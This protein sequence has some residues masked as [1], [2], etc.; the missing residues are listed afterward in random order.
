V[1]LLFLS[2]SHRDATELAVRL[3]SDLE[4]A[5]YSV[6]QDDKRI[7][8]GR[9]WTDEIRQG[10]RESQLVIAVLSPQAV[11]RKGWDRNPDDQDSVCLD[12]IEYA[13][14]ACRVPVLPIM[15]MSCEAPFRIF[16]LQYLD[17]RAWQES[18][19]H[20]ED[21]RRA[22]HAAVAECLQTGRVPLRKWE[23]LPEPC[24]FTAFIAERRRWFTGR[25]WLLYALRDRVAHGKSSTILLTGS[26]GIGK[27]A[28]VANL[29]HNNPAGQILAYHCCQATIPATLDPAV[30]VRSLASMLAARDAA[31]AAMI[32]CQNSL[33][34]LDEARVAADPASAFENVILNQLHKLPAPEAGPRILLIDALDEAVEWHRSPNLLDL[35]S[36]RLGAFP[37]WLKIVATTRDVPGV[38]HRLRTA[39]LLS[40]DAAKDDNEKDLRAYVT[41]RL[42]EEPLSTIAVAERHLITDNVLARGAGNFLVVTQTLEALH[43]KLIGVDELD[44]LA[45][46]LY[47]SY[48]EFFERLY[49]R[50]GVDFTP[51][52]AVLQGIIAA[53]EPPS[54]DE[55]AAVVGLDADSDLSPILEHL[56]PLVVQRNKR[57]NLFH[58]T[59]ADWLTGWEEDQR[60]AREYHISPK[61]GHKL[62]ADA[63]LQVYSRG[64]T[65]WNL[66]VRRYLPTHLSGA[67]W[68]E[69]LA[70][71]LFDLR[72]LHSKARGP[73]STIFDVVADFDLAGRHLPHGDA[74]TRAIRLLGD[75]LRKS[76]NV[77]ARDRNQIHEQLFGRLRQGMSPEL[78]KLREGLRQEP[79]LQKLRARFA[80]L[81]PA[82]SP[83]MQTLTGH[84]DSVDGALLLPGGT[85]ALSWSRDGTL[86]RWDLETGQQVGEP[87]AG[88]EGS[89]RGALLL[90][91]GTHALSWSYDDTLRRWDLE[92]GQQVGDPF[93]GPIPWLMQGALLLPDGKHALSWSLDGTLRRWNLE[94]G[95]Q[96]GRLLAGHEDSVHGALLLPDGK[97]ALSWSNDRTLRRWDL[98][99]GQQVGEPFA[100]H[101]ELVKGA[102]LLPDGQ[103]TLSWSDDRTL[104][105]WDLKTGQ[106]V[107]E[108]LAGHEDW[109]W[110][111][112]LMPDGKHA[113]SW[114]SDSTLRRWDLETSKQLGEP[115]IGHE[116]LVR[117]ALLMP[118]G[119]HTLSWSDDRTL[120]RWD[121]KTGQQVGEPLA[122]HEDWVWGT[123]LMPDGTHALSW[124]EDRTLRRWDLET[125]QHVNEPLTGHKT[126]VNDALLLPSG[127]QALSWS[128]DGTLRRWDL[129]TGQQVGEPLTGHQ[130]SIRIV[131]LLPDGKHA[132][133]W[134]ID[135]TL[136]RWDL[137]EGREVGEPLTGP[138]AWLVEGVLLLPDGKQA[139]SWLGNWTLRRWELAT[140]R[141]LGEPLVGHKDWVNGALLL[142]DGK[143]ALS[144]SNDQTLRRWDLNTGQQMGA[145]LTGHKDRVWGAL[146][147]P[148][149][150]QALSWSGDRTLRRWDLQTGR[151]LTEHEAAVLGALLLPDGKQALYWSLDGTL[152]R[153]DLEIEQQV[154]EPLAGHENQVNGALLLPEG[155]QVLSWSD[156]RTVRIWDLTMSK[157]LACFYAEGR[158]TALVDCGMARFFAADAIGRVYFLEMIGGEI[159]GVIPWS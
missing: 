151:Q 76:A 60:I 99:T 42:Q 97:Q 113:L 155:K 106:Q 9:A 78:D 33:G 138:I 125:G 40:L 91:G 133:S 1:P 55:L 150:K 22:L 158:V 116:E 121:L 122:G 47:P 24:D 142:P 20:Y 93:A 107:G 136:R 74:A 62:W 148:D 10:L 59:L 135:R 2:Y 67:G 72:F 139:L 69:Q 12:E 127:K 71:V 16:R 143:H 119:T 45:P 126:W 46:G 49:G 14:D 30:F 80:N 123:L 66:A 81:E 44:T 140:R 51:S 159:S 115:L 145:P 137:E 111:A 68:Y 100:G 25:T 50:A 102:L 112:L 61:R 83:L 87:F 4:A 157:E 52:R 58:K 128:R 134:S 63:L 154:G 56:A 11:S 31:Y 43:K 147:L 90:P 27:S 3:R 105:R 21:L 109:V 94:T 18:A 156:D 57:Y 15:A 6:W 104:R 141:L 53:Q 41:E 146:L 39:E 114:S 70:K 5:G 36:A 101:E 96:V 152:R 77:L 130:D 8:A 13:I 38:R 120:R 129:E 98:E 88:H 17:F 144:W 108:P 19:T 26:P 64:P 65:A 82:G 131:L 103:H 92:T 153:W 75:A 7:R 23:R 37:L 28:F 84:E 35:L 117:G 73:G 95:Q 79:G 34:A 124:S 85:H 118:D 86:R 110:G 48:E 32:E 54:R 89:V 29:V 149:G 132:L